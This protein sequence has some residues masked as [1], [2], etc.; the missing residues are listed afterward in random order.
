MAALRSHCAKPK[1]VSAAAFDLLSR[2]DGVRM[3]SCSVQEI[4][5]Q[6]R[7]LENGTTSY[8]DDIDICLS[9][10]SLA[11][12]EKALAPKVHIDPATMLPREFLRH[13]KAFD[14]R[15]AEELPP[16]RDCDHKIELKPGS[17]TPSGPLYGMSQDELRVL[18][19]F[20]DDNLAKGFI[21]VSSSPAAS[22][23]LFAKKPGGGLR[24]CVDYRSLNAI[25]IK[26]RYPLPLSERDSSSTQ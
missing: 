3:F 1:R 9:G 2:Q 11:D 23:V 10:A 22:P 7:H 26:N 18:R 15:A 16:H 13:V 24:F 5:N 25:T 8:E 19:K 21:R 6:I 4:D 20:L 12:V 17:Q 14:S